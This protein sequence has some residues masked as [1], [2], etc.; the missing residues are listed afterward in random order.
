MIK[1]ILENSSREIIEDKIKI[2]ISVIS[3]PSQKTFI[4]PDTIGNDIEYT[5]YKGNDYE[6]IFR[7]NN[8]NLII[9]VDKESFYNAYPKS[10][11]YFILP[12][13]LEKI[14]GKRAKSIKI[15]FRNNNLEDIIPNSFQKYAYK[16][17]ICNGDGEKATRFDEET[18][19]KISIPCPCAYY[20]HYTEIVINQINFDKDLPKRTIE[21]YS[22]EKNSKIKIKQVSIQGAWRDIKSYDEKSNI[23][24]LEELKPSC[25][26]RYRLRFLC[27]EA[28][29]INVYEFDG[30][31]YINLQGLLKNLLDLSSLTKGQI[32]GIPLELRVKRIEKTI[33]TSTGNITQIYPRVYIHLPY[34]LNHLLEQKTENNINLLNNN[35]NLLEDKNNGD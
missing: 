27:P 2:G 8:G 16:A 32:S 29:G 21:V 19:Q 18:G 26:V 9:K 12:P 3:I 22:R 30:G 6:V 20:K 11:D 7:Q 33:K 4:L 28:E 24:Y 13:A 5:N 17:L 14:Y 15:I 10:L 1:G 35:N 23:L 31:G 34:S 25:D